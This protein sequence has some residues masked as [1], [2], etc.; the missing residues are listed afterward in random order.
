MLNSTKS[1]C[2]F[3][4]MLNLSIEHDSDDYNSY[5]NIAAAC[6]KFLRTASLLP[7]GGFLG[8]QIDTKTFSNVAFSGFGVKATE[9]D[10]N[11]IFNQCATASPL[12]SG[13]MEDLYAKNRKVYVLSSVKGSARDVD[14]PEQKTDYFYDDNYNDNYYEP[15]SKDSFY[16]MYEMMTEIGA[17][18]RIT[19]GST[20]EKTKGHGRIFISLPDEITLRMRGMLSFAFP[21]MVADEVAK[22]PEKPDEM[23]CLPDDCF[24]ESMTRILSVLVKGKDS[25]DPTDDILDTSGLDDI[26]IMESTDETLFEEDFDIEADDDEV[27]AFTPIDDLELSVRACNCLKRAGINSVE[28]LKTLSDE[29][30]T[31]VRNL[32][33]K[34]IEEIKL[35][36]AKFQGSTKA[37]PLQK[38]N[39]MTKLDELIGLTDVKDQIRKIVAFA[40]MKQDM[41]KNGNANISVALNMGFVGNPGTAKTTV[42]RIVAGIFYEIGLLS[43]S[44]LIE[45]GRADLVAEYIGQTAVKV[46]NVFRKAKGKMLFIDEAYSLV[47]DRKGSF[48][49]EAINTIIQEMENNR[50]QTIVIFAGY[51]ENME[52]F[53]SRNP[54]L[55]SRVPFSIRF[56][57]YS[58]EEMVK[59]AEFEA[60]NRGFS[61]DTEAYEKVTAICSASALHL[62][63]GNGRFCR[64]L[65]EN[66]IL[67]YASRIYGNDDGDIDKNNIL[68][69]EDFTPPTGMNDT[70]KVPIGFHAGHNA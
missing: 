1:K 39:Y 25:K 27:E 41:L 7:D 65:I 23:E 11:W 34:S 3:A 40:K 16:D 66:A 4:N 57:D 2:S 21:H 10:F 44:E 8:W 22:L 43:S 42:A 38:I 33:R 13:W 12:T 61:I 37:A 59:I 18:I 50:D 9:E 51:P 63:G 53:F 47:D 29:D 6:K 55:R 60:R 5:M 62:D 52:S 69:A 30:L 54:G 56:S 14:V 20:T 31:H 46:K 26:E 48:G 58:V 35:K 15:L 70:K 45:V 28:E 19:A 24:L 49:D 64:N 68:I 67:G 17:V 36:I 32:G